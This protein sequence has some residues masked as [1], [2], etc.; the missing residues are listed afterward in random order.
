VTF[1]NSELVFQSG[2]RLLDGLEVALASPRVEPVSEGMR[3]AA[4]EDVVRR[5]PWRACAVFE[6][7]VRT[8][9]GGNGDL[10]QAA[11][12]LLSEAR[13]HVRRHPKDADSIRRVI[14]DAVFALA[15]IAEIDEDLT[16]KIVDDMEDLAWPFAEA[17]KQRQL[18]DEK[19]TNAEEDNAR[20]DKT[21]KSRFELSVNRRKRAVLVSA[22]GIVMRPKQ[23]IWP[24]HL[25]RGTQELFSGKP[26][27]G[28]S[29]AQI[30]LVARATRGDGWPDGA[31]GVAP[32][33]VIMLTAEDSLD[34]EVIP[35]LRAADAN[36]ARIR[37][38][39]SIKRDTNGDRMFL[40][41]ED[42]E[43]LE[44]AIIDWGMLA[45]S[46]SIPSRRLWAM[47]DLTLAE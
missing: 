16:T 42:L 6:S 15:S 12:E 33:N 35:R 30:D 13:D 3:M 8:F 40:L 31:R 21:T 7:W 36:L 43:D 14:N 26:G 10:R 45:S 47:A 27:I 19:R 5:L 17:P 1:N 37:F 46:R 25:L 11:I 4:L 28:K 23:W 9:R 22:V 41:G 44:R 34:Q 18:N 39:V 24:G 2:E 20:F 32:M 38:L 29:Q